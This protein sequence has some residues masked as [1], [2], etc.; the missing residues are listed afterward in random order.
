MRTK[1]G[2]M[3]TKMEKHLKKLEIKGFFLYLWLHLP[4]EDKREK[5]YKI[6]DNNFKIYD[7]KRKIKDWR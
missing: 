6:I 1:G 2:K 7:L 3:R 4:F 5:M